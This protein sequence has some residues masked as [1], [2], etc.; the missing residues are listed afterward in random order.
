MVSLGELTGLLCIAIII[1]VLVV[2]FF[3]WLVFKFIIYFL[4]SIIVAILVYLV[5]GGNIGLTVVAFVLSAIIFAA[6][7]WSRKREYRR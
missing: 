2:F 4:P 5:T 3:I 6:W 1:I 7:G